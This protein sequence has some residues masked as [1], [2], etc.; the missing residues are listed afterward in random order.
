[1]LYAGSPVGQPFRVPEDIVTWMTGAFPRKAWLTIIINAVLTCRRKGDPLPDP[2]SLF[3]RKAP[4]H[5]G[6]DRCQGDGKPSFLSVLGLGHSGG[7]LLDCPENSLKAFSADEA[8]IGRRV[9]FS[10]PARGVFPEVFQPAPDE[11]PDIVGDD[12]FP[13]CKPGGKARYPHGRRVF[14]GYGDQRI[15]LF[16]EIRPRLVVF[17]KGS[18]ASVPSGDKPFP[19]RLS[20]RQE[21]WT[22]N[23]QFRISFRLDRNPDI[24]VSPGLSAGDCFGDPLQGGK[25]NGWSSEVLRETGKRIK[26]RVRCPGSSNLFV[27]RS[28]NSLHSGG[29]PNSPAIPCTEGTHPARAKFKTSSG[30]ERPVSFD[31]FAF[32]QHPVVCFSC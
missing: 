15:Q 6:D 2:R 9:G 10:R 31:V 5:P 28:K 8:P 20:R 18:T 24:P 16:M 13:G 1:V 29:L 14:V 4:P 32:L 22:I 12:V 30:Q 7:L 19:L 27:R 23:R 3:R 17:R 25:E 26:C 11:F 21:R